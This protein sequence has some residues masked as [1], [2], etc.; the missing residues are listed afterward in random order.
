MKLRTIVALLFTVFCV[1]WAETCEKQGVMTHEVRIV[2]QKSL[3]TS[4]IL[5][6]LCITLI[7][8][9]LALPVV[10]TRYELRLH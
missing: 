4:K 10:L 7:H 5:T 8:L 1:S 9:G 3:T 6:L 2:V